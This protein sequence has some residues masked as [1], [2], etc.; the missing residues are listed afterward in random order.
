MI[1]LSEKRFADFFRSERKTGMGYWIVTTVLLD[2]RE[3]EQTVVN[4][5][6]VTRVRGYP[7]IPFTEAEI[8]HFVVTH[9]KWDFGRC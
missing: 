8:D 4:S 5:G 6:Y 2:G 3:F 1:A 9:D 7:A